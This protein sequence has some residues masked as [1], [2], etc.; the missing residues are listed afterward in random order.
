MLVAQAANVLLG[1]GKVYFD[2]FS[3]AGAAQGLRFL[4][5]VSKLEISTNDEKAQ[6]YDYSR[7]DAPLL[8]EAL[9]RR[10]VMVALTLQEFSQSN[11]AMALMGE[12][13]SYTQAATP[14]VD[15]SVTTSVVK[16][17]VYQVAGRKIGSVTVK[18]GPSTAL[19]LGTDYDIADSELGLIHIREGSV[20]LT[21]G[22]AVLVSYTPTLI[23]TPGSN[24]VRGA[25]ASRILGKLVYVGDPA[26]GIKWDLEM[27]KVSL[28]PSGAVGFI[29][30]SEYGSFELSGKVLSDE[31]GHA[32][33]PYY[34]LT[35]R[36]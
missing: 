8:D 2:R 10:E 16:G 32:S 12:E 36:P 24:R 20:T 9:S 18:K 31:T 21:N 22:D 30:E 25:N 14:V 11:L 28:T 6:V 1:R 13:V 27:W 19:V 29:T 26:A 34:R 17:R 4:G 35:Q 3:T 5:T 7:S 33:E 15:E 23:S